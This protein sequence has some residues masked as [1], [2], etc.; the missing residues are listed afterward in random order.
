MPTWLAL[1]LAGAAITGFATAA[2][3]GWKARRQ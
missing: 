1:G 3:H 2:W